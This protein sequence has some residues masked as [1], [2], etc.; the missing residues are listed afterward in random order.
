MIFAEK[1]FA[2]CSHMPPKDTTSPNFHGENFMNS[3]KSSKSTK[4]FSLESFSAIRYFEHVT[5][6]KALYH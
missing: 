5:K 6:F 3:H 1:T 2:G 4:F